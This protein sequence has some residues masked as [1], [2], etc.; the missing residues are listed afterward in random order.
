MV[1][2]TINGNK[3]NMNK[4]SERSSKDVVSTTGIK[5]GTGVKFASNFHSNV[6]K[7]NEQNLSD[8]DVDLAR[9]HIE[10]AKQ[11]SGLESV[12]NLVTAGK[13]TGGDK[14][15]SYD[16]VTVKGKTYDTNTEYLW[17]DPDFPHDDAIE[18]ASSIAEKKEG[19]DDNW[20][21]FLDQID[22]EKFPS[23]FVFKIESFLV[24][25]D[26]DVTAFP[27]DSP[28]GRIDVDSLEPPEVRGF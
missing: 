25:P 2:K 24:E 15:F 14:W 8:Q 4:N 6:T 13:W 1:F 19:N 5:I 7:K 12:G 18:E 27:E 3:V 23:F 22:S 16:T 20:P 9:L 10:K 26:G 11:K 17:D 21:D 28:I